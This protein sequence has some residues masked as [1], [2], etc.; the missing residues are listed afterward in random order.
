[1]LF[2]FLVFVGSFIEL[3]TE[4][5]VVLLVIPGSA[6]VVALVG[7][8]I[9]GHFLMCLGVGAATGVGILVLMAL[10]DM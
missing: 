8:A 10:A 1:L 5:P 7:T 4:D 9:F 6:L 3:I 2:V